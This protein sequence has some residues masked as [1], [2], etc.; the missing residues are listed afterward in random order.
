MDEFYEFW[1]QLREYGYLAR[2]SLAAHR[3]RDASYIL[4]IL[5]ELAYVRVVHISPGYATFQSNPSVALQI[6]PAEMPV[7][8]ASSQLQLI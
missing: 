1:I 4:P 2:G 3:E 8:E 5:A 7:S 6:V